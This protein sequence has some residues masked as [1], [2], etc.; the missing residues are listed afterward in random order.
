ML[1]HPTEIIDPGNERLAASLGILPVVR[2][3][4]AREDQEQAGKKNQRRKIQRSLE[5]RGIRLRVVEF[6][7]DPTL[8]TM[9]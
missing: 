6:I 3:G 2:R 7:A 1:V 4:K 8:A 5:E 9:I